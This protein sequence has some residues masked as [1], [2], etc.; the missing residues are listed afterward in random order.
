MAAM[1]IRRVHVSEAH[2]PHPR[3]ALA[4]DLAGALHWH[5]THLGHGEGLELLSE[6]LAGTLLGRGQTVHLAVVATA[7]PRQRTHDHAL[8]VEDVEVPP[9]H[10]LDMVVTGHRGPGWRSFLRPKRGRLLDL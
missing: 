1:G 9:L 10:R 5:L 6:V 3:V 2:L 4:E 7:S 8:L